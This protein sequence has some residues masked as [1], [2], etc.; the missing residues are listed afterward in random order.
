MSSENRERISLLAD[1]LDRR[2]SPNNIFFPERLDIL[3]G[4]S[5][6]L[7]YSTEPLPP[8][9]FLPTPLA[10]FVIVGIEQRYDTAARIV[11]NVILVGVDTPWRRGVPQA[12][13]EIVVRN[14]FDLVTENTIRLT[15]ESTEA[16]VR[17]LGGEKMRSLLPPLSFSWLNGLVGEGNGRALRG[18][19]RGG[20]V[21]GSRQSREVRTSFCGRT[22][23]I[24]RSPGGELRIFSRTVI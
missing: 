7:I 21:Y 14:S 22:L 9:T 16:R 1:C 12:D 23:R 5:W 18:S 6:N 15:L 17:G 8:V 13:A 4:T 19:S 10:V 11:D 2:E 3:D 24:A 20:G